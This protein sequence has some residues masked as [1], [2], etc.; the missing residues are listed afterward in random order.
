MMGYNCNVCGSAGV[1]AFFKVEGVP[2]HCNR[3]WDT[4]QAALEAPTGDIVLGFCGRCGQIFNLAFD[5]GKVSYS[6]DYENSLF[7]SPRFRQYADA[8]AE[9]LVEKYELRHKLI[10]E[11]GSGAGDFLQALCQLGDNRGIGFDP[12]F[13]PDSQASKDSAIRY[14][15]EL[16]S[17]QHLDSPPDLICCRHVLEHLADPKGLLAEVRGATPEKGETVLFFEVPNAWYTF[18]HLG[19]WD[20]IYE[21]PSYFS[22]SALQ[23]LFEESG[24]EVTRLAEA[25]GGQFLT[26]EARPS[27]IEHTSANFDEDGVKALASKAAEFSQ[28]HRQKMAY[29]EGALADRTAAKKNVLAW[30]AGSKG[31]TFLNMLEAAKAIEHI[32]D[33]NPRKHGR[34]VPVSGQD[35]ISPERLPE[36]RPDCIILMNPNY[37]AEVEQ[38]L[39]DLG[40][41]VELLAA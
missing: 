8:L 28:H 16:F 9:Y 29:W 5:P 6:P 18:G 40:L 13:S 27:A 12:S 3:L 37:Q 15:P 36:L 32:V 26:L 20:L 19:I 39:S 25:F 24:F 14:V 17:A 30:G 35:I 1:Q 23:V 7:F 34:F 10:V 4:R 11:I 22:A 31:V 38:M 21:H 33:I 41:E 2:V